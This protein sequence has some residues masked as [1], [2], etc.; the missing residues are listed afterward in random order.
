MEYTNINI[1]TNKQWQ[2]ARS[3]QNE[4]EKRQKLAEL[5]Y[6]RELF[7]DRL[8]VGEELNEVQS[9]FDHLE[10]II[11]K[12]EPVNNE[13]FSPEKTIIDPETNGNIPYR[14]YSASLSHKRAIEFP[15]DTGTDSSYQSITDDQSSEQDVGS[16]TSPGRGDHV[17]TESPESSR[18]SHVAEHKNG[19]DPVF[20]GRT[21]DLR[22]DVSN[23]EGKLDCCGLV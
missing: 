1:D 18:F 10:Q 13:Q 8:P 15:G 23:T 14:Y 4:V 11:E 9:Y 19:S 3:A 7:S 12:N 20:G 2:H 21:T 16:P 5:G 6:M 22:P 17:Q